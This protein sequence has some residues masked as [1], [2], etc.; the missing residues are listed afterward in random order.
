M[1]KSE[2]K[3]GDKNKIIV[4]TQFAKFVLNQATLIA[5]EEMVNSD[6]RCKKARWL[7]LATHL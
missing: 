2:D 6:Y 3:N 5:L 1:K 4:K 7:N